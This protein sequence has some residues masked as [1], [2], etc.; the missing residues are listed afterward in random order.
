MAA[1][2]VDFIQIDEPSPAIHPEAPADFAGLLNAARRRRRRRRAA[3]RPPLLRQ[4]HGPA[5][6]QADLPAGARPAAR[7]RVD[8]L[9]LEFANREMTEL[10]L[11]RGDRRRDRRPRR[12]RRRREE[13]LPR[14]GRGCRRAH[15]PRPGGRACP[16]SACR[17]CPTAA[18]ARPPAG[19]H[20]PSCT[21]SW[22]ARVSSPGGADGVEDRCGRP[23]APRR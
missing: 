19:L 20:G 13:L 1:A 5:A 7:F 11:L 10:D 14:D 23:L 3:G 18:S 12:R 17:S 9:V 8:E 15:R 4:L 22:T 16:R 2:G 21:P 6:R